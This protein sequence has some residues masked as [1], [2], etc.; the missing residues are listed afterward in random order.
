[1]AKILSRQLTRFRDITFVTPIWVRI[2]YLWV[3]ETL[4]KYLSI[5]EGSLKT[6]T[7]MSVSK[8]REQANADFVWERER[9]LWKVRCF[10]ALLEP[11]SVCSAV[12]HVCVSDSSLRSY[13]HGSGIVFITTAMINHTA[14]EKQQSDPEQASPLH[15]L[16]THAWNGSGWVTSPPMWLE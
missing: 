5:C 2:A 7:Q 13:P 9:T 15:T 6:G 11:M 4:G 1:M 12:Y 10:S 3:R 16:G 14:N 8:G